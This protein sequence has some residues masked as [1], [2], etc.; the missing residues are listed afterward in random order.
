M[1]MQFLD[2]AAAAIGTSEP[3]LRLIVAL[4]AGMPL[5]LIYNLCF[6]NFSVTL[7]V[8]KTWSD[9]LN[10]QHLFF[11]VTGIALSYFGFG[12]IVNIRFTDLDSRRGLCP[13]VHYNHGHLLHLGPH[14]VSQPAGCRS[15]TRFRLYYGILSIVFTTTK[16]KQFISNP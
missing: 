12:I 2:A 4:L 16:R 3:A 1:A 8:W 11:T 14:H 13:F 10:L 6:V 5:S 15:C 7:K 9:R